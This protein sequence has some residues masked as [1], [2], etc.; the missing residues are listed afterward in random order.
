MKHAIGVDIGG[1]TVKLGIF[2]THGTLLEKW[3]IPTRV[4]EHGK[5]I[6][7]DIVSAIHV[8]LKEAKISIESVIGIG[9]GVPGP[10]GEDGTVYK[11]ANLGW[12]TCKP[13]ED[14]QRLTGI[15]VKIAND[16][17]VAAL[18]EMWQGGGRGHQN[19][20][21]VTLGTG[22]GSGIIIGGKILPGKNGSAGEIGHINVCERETEICGC[23]KR[24]CM[25]QY[26]SAN[27]IVRATKRYL[28]TVP[29]IKSTL[30]TIENLTCKEIF[31]QALAGDAIA[32]TMVSEAGYVIGKGL[33]MIANT[34]DPEVFVIGGGV[35]RAGEQLL[36]PVREFY[37]EFS[38][39]AAANTEIKQAE[40]GNDAGIYGCA[41]MVMRE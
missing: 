39:H 41:K 19:V 20:V 35:S 26:A 14:M 3:E 12:G 17:N 25:E 6:I 9:L 37:K 28:A 24:G 13:A 38:F 4:E 1:T 22:V 21:M 31:E 16:A 23:G 11:C 40:L 33:A 34:L 32:E 29:E 8:K 2:N 36:K 5:N 27:G 18:G 7:T 30:R 10:V 15:S